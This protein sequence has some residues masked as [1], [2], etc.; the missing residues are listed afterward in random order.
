MRTYQRI[1]I[2]DYDV[3]AEN[4]DHFEVK[5]GKEYLTSDVRDDGSVI[6]FTRYW[7]PA[8][9]SIFAGELPFTR[10]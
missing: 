5:R 4:G 7:H 3:L 9:V 6:V 10:Q 2:Q 1:C 8:P